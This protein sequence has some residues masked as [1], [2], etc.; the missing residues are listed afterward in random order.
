MDRGTGYLILGMAAGAIL[1]YMAY[2]HRDE[3]MDKIRELEV[4]MSEK[5]VE[6][7]DKSEEVFTKAKD[8]FNDLVVKF[9]I[10]IDKYHKEISSEKS[11]PEIKEEIKKELD[12]VKSSIERL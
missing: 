5:K 3:I 12:S 7:L 9:E 1:G 8:A 4:Q 10:L 2:R 6:L 11:N